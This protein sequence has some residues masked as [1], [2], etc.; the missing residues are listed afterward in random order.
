MLKSQG[1]DGLAAPL[2]LA[3][4]GRTVVGASV[5]R[6]SYPE[7]LAPR[8]A[9]DTPTPRPSFSSH[10]GQMHHA[11]AAEGGSWGDHGQCG[12]GCGWGFRCDGRPPGCLGVHRPSRT[13]A[14]RFPA[15]LAGG[16]HRSSSHGRRGPRTHLLTA[17]QQAQQSPRPGIFC[18]RTSSCGGTPSCP[19]S[20]SRRPAGSGS[21][22]DLEPCPRG[23]KP[24]PWS[25]C[26]EL[27]PSC[28][29]PVEEEPRACVSPRPVGS[30]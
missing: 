17:P 2:G 19:S 18:G 8:Q 1:G 26:L 27:S 21:R 5:P 7:L 16:G 25:C 20:T 24:A 9:V 23:R 3:W 11:K 30:R 14:Q 10:Q 29:L 15:A 6:G 13:P 22:A 28:E 12:Q 4:K